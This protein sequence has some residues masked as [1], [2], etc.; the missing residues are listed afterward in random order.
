[1]MNFFNNYCYN[2]LPKSLGILL[3]LLL[4]SIN[5]QSNFSF[6]EI[7]PYKKGEDQIQIFN[8]LGVS[9]GFATNCY[10]WNHPDKRISDNYSHPNIKSGSLGIYFEGLSYRNFSSIVN[11]YWN[12]RTFDFQY[13]TRDTSGYE[14]GKSSVTNKFNFFVFSVSEKFRIIKTGNSEKNASIYL[15]CGLRGNV[16]ISAET[17]YDFVSTFEN[18]NEF[19]AGLWT[20]LGGEFNY[21][22][23]S[24][25]ADFYAAPDF[26]KTLNTVEGQYRNTEFGITFGFGYRFTGRK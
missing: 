3:F 23:F 26:T 9:F 20:G 13:S 7:N 16:Q 17:D 12:G 8:G 25:R 21:K 18:S 15:Y 4:E 6:D 10:G 19:N 24:M 1:M 5:A 2:H 22:H 11:L 14:I